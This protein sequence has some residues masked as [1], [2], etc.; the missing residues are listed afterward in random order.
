MRYTTII[1]ITEFP[2]LYRNPGTRLV[3]LH[4]CLRSGYHDYD[5]DI[6]RLS[7]R[8]LARDTGLT[9]AAVRHAIAQL[10][11]YEMI[12]RRPEGWQVR[13]FVVEQPISK[14]ARTKGEVKQQQQR[15]ERDRAHEQLVN[16]RQQLQKM[17][18]DY[19]AQGK[20][21]F[22]VYYEEMVKKA[23]AGD[24]QAAAWTAENSKTYE[25]HAAQVKKEHMNK[26]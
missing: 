24:A 26:S 2:S 19:W 21:S 9:L 10:L 17:V 1:D 18:D 12:I 7:L 3:Y 6:S 14:R 20:T 22:M 11:K 13:K 23:M 16:Q 5:R 8:H 4:L 15:D 25:Q